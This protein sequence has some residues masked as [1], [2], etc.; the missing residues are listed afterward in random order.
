MTEHDRMAFLES[1]LDHLQQ[2]KTETLKALEG[3]LSVKNLHI[4]LNKLDNTDL[5]I[6]NAYHKMISLV[7]LSGSGFF[8]VEEN[9][10]HFTPAKFF[11]ESCKQPLIEEID[12]LIQDNT[13]S[14]AV[15]SNSTIIIRSKELKSHVLLHALATVS[16]TRGV[17][18]AMLDMPKEDIPD[19]VFQ[20]ITIMMNDTA[21]QIESY[22]LYNRN[23]SA[24]KLLSESVVRLEESEKKL[25]NF[26]EKLEQEVFNR[27]KELKETN[28]L[29]ENE[30]TER[31]K[32]EK[33]LLQQKEA[34]QTLNETLEHRV[35]IETENRR[36]SERILHE[37][38][39]LAAMGQMMKAVAHQWRQPLNSLGLLI[40]D[41][42]DEYAHQGISE[43]YLKDSVDKSLKLLMHMSS[44]I[45][46]F[47]DIVRTDSACDDFDVINASSEVISLLERQY[48]SQGIFFEMRIPEE[49]VGPDRSKA[50][51]AKGDS[52]MYK[53][54]LINLLSNSKDAILDKLESGKAER[55]LITLDIKCADCKAYIDIED[56]GGGIPDNII[57]RIFEPYFTTKKKGT[58]IGL[59]M[60]SLVV[61]EQMSG[62]ITVRN[63]AS[64]AVFS[65]TLPASGGSSDQN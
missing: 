4:S 63:S 56:N 27:T 48:N 20:L 52:G 7:K 58:G 42:L 24:N 28:E 25:R 46:E 35:Q 43:E 15:R 49:C 51:M 55:G 22:E 18:I 30:I 19:A 61:N 32:I 6:D 2:E 17:F 37:Q 5:I 47:T 62:E 16:R 57:D 40:Q 64:G 33:L 34:L 1:K 38:S 23:K 54:V 31:K 10:G 65:L 59:Y 41:M 29:L 3:I 8:L 26:N 53:Q 45:D 44:T 14:L 60:S 36:K 39:K 50:L 12:R 11:P 21:H 13:F 9:T